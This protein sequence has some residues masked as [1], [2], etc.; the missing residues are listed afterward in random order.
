MDEL[1]QPKV[2]YIVMIMDEFNDWFLDASQEVENCITKLTQKA[3]AAGIH[4][5]LAT[6]RPSADVIKGSIKANVTTRFAFKVSS[7][8]D[9]V[10]I[11]NQSGAEKLEGKG[12]VIVRH[13]GMEDTRLQAAFISDD[14]IKRIT[15]FLRENNDVDYI[16]D[17]EEIKQ[18]CSQRGAGN[19]SSV[20]DC[21][22]NDPLFKEV[23]YFVVR[24]NNAS[25]NRLQKIFK[26]GFN[27][28]DLIFTDLAAMGIVTPAVQ[29]GRREVLV[30]EDELEKIL[31]TI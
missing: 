26:T 5:I 3:R 8:A 14:E 10:V 19:G 9:S 23:A 21:G 28:M 12:D 24:N 29:G 15:N 27:R 1:K 18:T 16:V 11:L 13:T 4:I 30:D 6:Q 31:A 7:Q 2:P 25:V 20:P 22:T 17:M